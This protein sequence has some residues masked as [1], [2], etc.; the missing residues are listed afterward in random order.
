MA[1][2]GYGEFAVRNSVERVVFVVVIILGSFA[3]S[4]FTIDLLNFLELEDK[5]LKAYR[6]NIIFYIYSHKKIRIPIKNK[7]IKIIN[8]IKIHKKHKFN[9]KLQKKCN[10][11]LEIILKITL[12]R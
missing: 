7:H 9:K 11:N 12:N 4:V 6:R 8:N 2:I 1:T 5:E 10:F 3:A